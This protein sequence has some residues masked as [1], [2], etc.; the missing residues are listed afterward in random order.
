[1]TPRE[2]RAQHRLAVA[3]SAL[4]RTLG[5]GP[6]PLAAVVAKVNARARHRRLAAAWM[7]RKKID[8]GDNGC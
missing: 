4:S 6:E 5:R 8:E 1:M 7:A 3:L 2:I